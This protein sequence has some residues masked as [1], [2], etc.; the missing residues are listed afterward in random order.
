M[1]S[2][3]AFKENFSELLNYK[4]FD[5]YLNLCFFQTEQMKSK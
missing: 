4:G 1:N 5:E 3:H 2:I